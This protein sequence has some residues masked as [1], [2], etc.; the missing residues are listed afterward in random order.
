MSKGSQIQRA[1]YFEKPCAAGLERSN[2]GEQS[3]YKTLPAET[4]YNTRLHCL[5]K[6]YT[7]HQQ[8]RTMCETSATL[9]V[10]ELHQPNKSA[11]P[12]PKLSP[13]ARLHG[14][15][16]AARRD[17]RTQLS[18]P[19]ISTLQTFLTSNSAGPTFVNITVAPRFSALAMQN[20]AQPCVNEEMVCLPYVCT[21]VFTVH[22]DTGPCR[23][24]QHPSNPA[25][26]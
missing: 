1:A 4:M 5:R 12:T 2:S 25:T 7:D 22:A 3:T 20:R 26:P 10:G 23:V 18:A 9:C 14:K 17:G 19:T 15:H 8:L 21:V 13:T 16:N 11:T 6:T 24:Y